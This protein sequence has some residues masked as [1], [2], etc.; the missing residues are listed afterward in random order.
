MPVTR[1]LADRQQHSL[2]VAPILHRDGGRRVG[3][4]DVNDCMGQILRERLGECL[5]CIEEPDGVGGRRRHSKHVVGKGV[6]EARH[7]PR[8]VH[9]LSH[10]SCC[11]SFRSCGMDDEEQ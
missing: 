9:D 7:R 4:N 3:G 5:E 10:E 6:R 2:D 1:W 8:L 11:V